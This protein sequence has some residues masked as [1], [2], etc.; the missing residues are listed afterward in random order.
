LAAIAA[1]AVAQVPP[2]SHRNFV[3]CPIVRDTATVPCWLSEYDG[4]LYYLGIQTDVS[5]DFDPPFLGHEVLVEGVISDA[6][7]VCGGIV[8]DPVRVSPMAEF[9]AECNVILPAQDR[10][11]VPFA[12]RPPGP[13]GGRLAYQQPPPAKEVLVPYQPREFLLYYDFDMLIMG[14]HAGT[15]GAIFEYAE[16]I[17]ARRITVT[18]YSGATLLSSRETLVE[19]GSIAVKRARE[20]TGLLEKAGLRNADFAVETARLEARAD[21]IDDWMSRRVSVVVAP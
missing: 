14:R 4:E 10:Y 16:A 13:S 12:P 15:L 6:P 11:T 21:G 18:G 9:R 7:R 8:L 2:D 1:P 5:A 19:D 3:S 20:V 17:D